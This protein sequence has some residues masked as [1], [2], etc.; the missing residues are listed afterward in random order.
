M[1]EYRSKEFKSDCLCIVTVALLLL[2]P[3][4]DNSLIA[5]LAIADQKL[6][7]VRMKNTLSIISQS[8]KWI[9]PE[10]E[11]DATEMSFE[12]SEYTQSQKTL[13]L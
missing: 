2:L 1:T 10:A 8:I 12:I 13:V 7:Y 3:N 6:L 4:T 11:A 5:L 9:Q